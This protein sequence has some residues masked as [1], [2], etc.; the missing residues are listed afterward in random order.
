MDFISS[1]CSQ[2]EICFEIFSKTAGAVM[3]IVLLHQPKPDV[4]LFI[5]MLLPHSPN[6]KIILPYK[7]KLQSLTSDQG[8]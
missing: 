7:N 2:Y 4:K 5:F 8:E 1:S 6:Q 3:E